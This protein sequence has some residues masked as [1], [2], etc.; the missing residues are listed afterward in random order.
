MQIV[1]K[2]QAL[3]EEVWS[4]P[5]TKLGEEYGMSDN[6]IRKVCKAMDI[7]L[8]KVG[9]WARVE[10]G[11]EVT[12]T[13]LPEEA[14][15]TTFVCR[16]PPRPSLEF[17]RP[18][19]AIWLEERLASEQR[20]ESLIIVDFPPRKWHKIL[21]PIRENLISSVKAYDKMIKAREKEKLRPSKSWEPNLAALSYLNFDGSLLFP[22]G[23]KTCFRVSKLTYQRALA[24]ANTLLLSAE[25]RGC[26]VTYDDHYARP[27]MCIENEVF[28]FA[29]RERQLTE[30]ALVS[31]RH[32]GSGTHK[33][34]IPTDK[35]ALVIERRFGGTFELLDREGC[36]LESQLNEL[37]IRLYRSAVDGRQRLRKYEKEANEWAIQRAAEEV[38]RRQR[39]YEAKVK[40]EEEKRREVLIIEATNW[41]QAQQIRAFVAEV[42]DRADSPPSPAHREWASWALGVALE[43]D[44]VPGRNLALQQLKEAE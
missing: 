40:E 23:Q 28:S 43:K 35:L 2:R 32:P 36:P 6:G 27:Q 22:R 26:A 21:I 9:H 37:F 44:P 10:A 20:P 14:E 29:I 17:K 7:P 16:P 3:Y 30:V 8:P 13:E 41:Q 38:I 19:D 4:T 5:L 15:R 24:I 1:F 11:Q 42:I 34:G 12:R 33:I 25:A 39:E 31:E 18:E